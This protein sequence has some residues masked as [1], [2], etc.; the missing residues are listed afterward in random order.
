MNRETRVRFRVVPSTCQNMRPDVVPLGK[1][2]Y[3]TFL[4][5]PRCKWVPNFGP[6]FWGLVNSDWVMCK[7]GK[8][9]SPIN[10]RANQ[11][12]YDPNLIPINFDSDTDKWFPHRPWEQRVPLQGCRIRKIRGR[13]LKEKGE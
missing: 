6:Q 8:M 2:L 5:P 10:F 13:I 7:D 12:L 11:I 9:Q 1:A 4:T 3:T